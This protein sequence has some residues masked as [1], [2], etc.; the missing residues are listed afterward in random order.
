[1]TSPSKHVMRKHRKP[2]ALL[3][4]LKYVLAHHTLKK[5]NVQ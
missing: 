5:S 3:P 4:C 2:G 1:M